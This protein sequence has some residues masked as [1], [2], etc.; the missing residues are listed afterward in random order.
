MTDTLPHPETARHNP[1]IFNVLPLSSG[2]K[3]T[4]QFTPDGDHYITSFSG[5]SDP[6]WLGET[7]LPKCVHAALEDHGAA[8]K[9]QPPTAPCTNL[10][11]HCSKHV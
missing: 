3:V 4:H 8:H 1:N 10:F 2:P 11:V 5:D 7:Q 9:G 6:I